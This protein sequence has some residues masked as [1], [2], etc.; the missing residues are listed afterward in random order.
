MEIV[1]V[2]IEK[3]KS[4]E[5]QGF[6]FGGEYFFDF[7]HEKIELSYR[8]N[9]QFIEGF[10]DS[11]NETGDLE[12]VNSTIIVGQNG[13][14]KTTILDF[15]CSCFGD[16]QF[17]SNCIIILKGNKSYIVIC[18]SIY[19]NKFQS[20]LD[21]DTYDVVEIYQPF[22]DVVSGKTIPP[23]E[24]LSRMN[25]DIIK[26]KP[27]IS[28]YSNDF[29]LNHK[30]YNT[31]NVTN[32]S[33][34]HFLYAYKKKLVENKVGKVIADSQEIY[35]QFEI[36]N[37][38]KF[39]EFIKRRNLQFPEALNITIFSFIP[40]TIQLDTRFAYL[41]DYIFDQFKVKF[42]DNEDHKLY[43]ELS[44]I[45]NTIIE[46]RKK[47]EEH[48]PIKLQ[49]LFSM[50]IHLIFENLHYSIQDGEK[51][52]LL[53]V[54]VNVNHEYSVLEQINQIQES[55]LKNNYWKF[56]VNKFLSIQEVVGKFDDFFVIET[57]FFGGYNIISKSLNKALEF[58]E[59][60]TKTYIGNGNATFKWHGISTGENA[61]LTLYS[62]FYA[63]R[64]T[65]FEQDT[66]YND[67]LL[68]LLDEPEI[69]M[70][71]MWQ[72]KL[73]KD[74]LKFIEFLFFEVKKEIRNL[75]NR[76]VQIVLTS[77]NPIMTSDF[78][79]NNVI[80]L[81]R[82]EESSKI[83]VDENSSKRQTLGANIHSLYK[84]AFYLKPPFIGKLA[85]NKINRTIIW[86]NN[87]TNIVSKEKHR[88]IIEMIGEPILKSKLLNMYYNKVKYHVSLEKWNK[89]IE[90]EI[91]K[92]KV[93]KDN[94]KNQT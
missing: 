64:K 94:D 58:I 72:Q 51:E 25:Y 90:E 85:E 80:Y 15:L 79:R 54:S 36:E 69:Y 44:R 21:K 14:G 45:R 9:E 33:T 34:N 63:N 62:R 57:D 89:N 83:Y 84:D 74:F 16:N 30:I 55:L 68:I 26:Y 29:N 82:D 48:E 92:L 37:Q 67:H 38:L 70:H 32:I 66:N 6:N 81:K 53:N 60:Y 11:N 17:F 56:E 86:L 88:K 4:I 87:S 13:A 18:T 93:K 65:I 35:K 52:R 7:D 8:K 23:N 42:K 73:M 41:D 40:D 10:W 28:F 39:V 1:Y 3:F 12:F 76:K 2:W 77:N 47:R 78:P 31:V 91:E 43:I 50:F 49:F 59:Y 5:K 71:P 61:L 24:Y 75:K 46:R 19:F 27:K 22:P 20:E